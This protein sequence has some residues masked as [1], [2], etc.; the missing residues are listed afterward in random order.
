MNVGKS[1]TTC[2]NLSRLLEMSLPLIPKILNMAHS[3]LF[4]PFMNIWMFLKVSLNLSA[5]ATIICE[6][7]IIIYATFQISDQEKKEIEPFLMLICKERM[8]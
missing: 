2:A 8:G 1:K 6:Q 3:A 7:Q 5:N 4:N